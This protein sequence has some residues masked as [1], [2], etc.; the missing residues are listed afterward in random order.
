MGYGISLIL[1]ALGAI[2]TWGVNATVTGIN[3]HAVG[4]I[5]MTVSFLGLIVTMLFWSAISPFGEAPVIHRRS[6]RTGIIVDD[7]PDVVIDRRSPRT[8]IHEP[9]EPRTSDE[10]S[11]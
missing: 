11:R 5:L 4:V 10:D 1:I 2:L 7:G 3:V 9:S 6:N 8:I